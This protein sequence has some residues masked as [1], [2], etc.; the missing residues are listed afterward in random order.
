[1]I[2]TQVLVPLLNAFMACLVIVTAVK[3]LSRNEVTL[4]CIIVCVSTLMFWFQ[5][6]DWSSDLALF[7][8]G[9]KVNPNNVKLRN[10]LAMELKSAGRL[11]EAQRQ[12][13]VGYLLHCLSLH[14][15]S[16]MYPHRR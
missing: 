1:M 14:H 8:S 3:T 16:L 2:S 7:M 5:F 10:N 11:E 15:S 6:Q 12:Y 9:V 4:Y 13:L